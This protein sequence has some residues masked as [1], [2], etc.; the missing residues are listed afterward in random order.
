M[1]IFNLLV[2][3]KATID[4]S[5]AP[6]GYITYGYIGSRSTRAELTHNG[7][8]ISLPF[9]AALT[10]SLTMGDGKYTATV[11]SGN[12]QLLTKRF[13]VAFGDSCKPFLCANSWVDI[14]NNPLSVAQAA[15][16]CEGVQRDY[17]KV[18]VIYDWIRANVKYNYPKSTE[19]KREYIPKPDGTMITRNGVCTDYSALMGVMLRSQGIPCRIA[20]GNLNGTAVR[21][22]W[23]EVYVDNRDADVRIRMWQRFDPTLHPEPERLNNSKY[24]KAD[25]YL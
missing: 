22:A 25:Y 1:G 10:L 15:A 9:V 16:L 3:G 2:P 5:T 24:Y 13:T 8:Q 17:D 6:G 11:S 14:H 7:K 23:V 20:I 18:L 19:L 12:L 21:H 4:I